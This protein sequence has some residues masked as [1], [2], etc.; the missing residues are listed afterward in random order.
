VV[1]VTL[2]GYPVEGVNLF[3]SDGVESV[4]ASGARGRERGEQHVQVRSGR[5]GEFAE[6]FAARFSATCRLAY[7]LCGDRSEG[8]EIAQNAF[9]RMYARWP[10]IRRETADAYL[11]TVVT[12]LF[13]DTRRR[14]RARERST[15]ELP[16]VPVPPDL[17]ELDRQPLQQALMLLPPRQRAVLL[18]R[19]AY[20]L[21]IDQVAA[22]LGCSEGTVKSQA[23][24]GLALLRDRYAEQGHYAEQ[25][26]QAH[27]RNDL[28][29]KA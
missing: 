4:Q 18:L 15:A 7:A 29:G 3:C 1:H 20:D 6:F 8:E 2:S 25:G 9:V 23:S 22:T 14:G 11:R 21:P 5:D 13:L 28:D 19:F 17:S 10:K 16:D 27:D 24:R 12:R 26:Q